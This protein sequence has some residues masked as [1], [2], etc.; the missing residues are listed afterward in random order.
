M[1][2]DQPAIQNTLLGLWEGMTE[3]MLGSS[4]L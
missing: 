3:G 1:D 2:V 4:Y